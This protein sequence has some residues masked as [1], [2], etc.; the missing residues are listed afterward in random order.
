MP[1]RKEGSIYPTPI[2]WSHSQNSKGQHPV[3]LRVTFQRQTRYYQVYNA[4]RSK[5]FLTRENYQYLTCS[6]RRN[7][8]GKDKVLREYIDSIAIKAKESIETITYKG[9]LPFDFTQFEKAYLG[10]VSNEY[11]LAYFEQYLN[12]LIINGQAGTYRCY[13]TPYATFK[14]FLG[15]DIYPSSITTNLLNEYDKYLRDNRL[16]D[17]TISIHMRCLRRVYNEMASSDQY[18]LTQYPFSKTIYDKKYKIPVSKGQK[19]TTL[20]KEDM[21]RFILGDVSGEENLTNPIY[22]A[23]LL[24]LFSF[25]AQGI[26]FKDLALLKN[27]DIKGTEIEFERIKTIRTRKKPEAIRIPITRE[28]ETIIEIFRTQ[29]ISSSEFIFGVFDSQMN[30]TEVRKDTI[31]RQFIITTNKWLSRFCKNNGLPKVTTYSARHTFA[32]IAKGYMPVA[33]I[34]RMLGH[35]KIE[36]TQIYLGRF[37]EE[38]NRKALMQVSRSVL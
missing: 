4:D 1:R 29:I 23:K 37:E 12:Q 10:E 20:S 15:R 38:E 13:R 22:K 19:G 18:L 7:L 9:H 8:R 11:F 3:K 24:L 26:S 2:L 31:I 25:F 21:K 30:L 28:I 35:T 16:C 33:Q 36:T 17:T 34:S 6:D 27:T 32:S 14:E 5:L